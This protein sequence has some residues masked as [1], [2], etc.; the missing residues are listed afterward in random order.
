MNHRALIQGIV[1]LLAIMFLFRQRHQPN[2]ITPPNEYQPYGLFFKVLRLFL[3]G[4]LALILVTSSILLIG[5]YHDAV[6]E[7]VPAPSQVE[8]PADLPFA[9][10]EVAFV[11][12]D[13]LKL[14]GWFVPPEN[15]ATIILLHGYGSNRLAMR[16]HAEQLVEA[17]YG[18]LMYDERASGESEGEYRSYGWEDSADVSGAVTFIHHQVGGKSNIGIAGCSIGGQIALQGI[19]IGLGHGAAIAADQEGGRMALA[20]MGAGDKGIEALDLVGK[21]MRGQEIQR[22]IGHWRLC[23]QTFVAQ[24]VEDVIGPKRAVLFQQNLE[25]PAALGGELQAVGATG[26]LLDGIRIDNL[27]D[28]ANNDQI[29]VFSHLVQLPRTRVGCPIV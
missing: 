29:S 11:S 14:T 23:A 9:V 22:A 10:E 2:E 7:T 4:M 5:A 24:P 13:G 19:G 18:V 15:G 6:S 26:S 20:H 21:A 1:L 25:H 28:S 27:R 12:A 16:W 8:I 17:N 3:F